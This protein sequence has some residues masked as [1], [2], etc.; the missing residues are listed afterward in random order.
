MR[1]AGTE[2]AYLSAA[3]ICVILRGP[4]AHLISNLS[5]KLTSPDDV[6]FTAD[7]VL[8]SNNAPAKLGSINS[9]NKLQTKMRMARDA[10]LMK[11][12]A[13]KRT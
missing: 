9:A 10:M 3:E 6:Q 2:G 5:F 4:G 11:M 13:H 12:A 7:L 8:H 1:R